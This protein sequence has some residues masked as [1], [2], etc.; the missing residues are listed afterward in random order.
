M[1]LL[2]VVLVVGIIQTAYLLEGISR[3]TRAMRDSLAEIQKSV[4]DR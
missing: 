2:I 3:N 1:T 4:A